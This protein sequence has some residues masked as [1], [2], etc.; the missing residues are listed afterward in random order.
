MKAFG[1]GLFIT[2][3][4][5]EDTHTQILPMPKWTRAVWGNKDDQILWEYA[6]KMDSEIKK[7]VRKRRQWANVVTMLECHGYSRSASQCSAR[8]RRVTEGLP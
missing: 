2:Y 4:L 8:W 6:S 5:P 3:L 7:G 1:S